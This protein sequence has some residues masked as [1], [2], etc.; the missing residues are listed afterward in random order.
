MARTIFLLGAGASRDAGLPLMP[1]LTRDFKPWLKQAIEQKKVRGGQLDGLFDQA[2]KVVST[3]TDDPN[4]ELVLQLLDD[5]LSFKKPS[6]AQTVVNWQQPFD[7]PDVVIRELESLI[8]Q[9]IRERLSEPTSR[10]SPEVSFGSSFEYLSGL[11]DFS[12]HKKDDHEPLHVFTLN[13]DRLVEWMATQLAV[14]FT[15]GF[16]EAWDP[17]LFELS[18]WDLCL[19]KL[20][21]SVDWYRLP[22]RNVIYRGSPIHPAFP[23]DRPQEV[24]LYPARGKAAHADPFATLVSHFDRAL[25]EAE[26]CIVIGYSFQDAHIRR[27]V[28]DRMVTN[29]RLQL[30]LVNPKAD[31]VIKIQQDDD[32]PPFSHFR[33]RITGLKKLA[34]DALENRAIIQRLEE[35]WSVDGRVEQVRTNRNGAAFAQAASDLFDVVEY[36]RRIDIP[37]KPLALLRTAAVGTQLHTALEGAIALRFPGN[38]LSQSHFESSGSESMASALSQYA[39]MWALGAAV[40]L[41]ISE[42]VKQEIRDILR[43]YASRVILPFGDD[44]VIWTGPLQLPDKQVMEKRAATLRSLSGDLAAHPPETALV[45][46]SMWLRDEYQ[47]LRRCVDSLARYYEFLSKDEVTR[48]SVDGQEVIVPNRWTDPAIR[49]RELRA[50]QSVDLPD[51]WMGQPML[52]GKLSDLGQ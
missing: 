28:L 16:G 32:E 26:L 47:A 46:G 42:R 25:A 50:L 6:T 15:S 4:I 3:G 33:D 51:S 43:Q 7:A 2:I 19:Y 34:K 1:E 49:L 23:D 9:Y 39:A 41:P 44:Y 29:R 52:K 45:I 22:A 20:H 21:G 5:L 14:T 31:E 10:P 30:L 40:R 17:S 12:D 13:Y 35:I 37:Y 11:L 8:R 38:S 48:L 27:L 18:R 36:C 24:L